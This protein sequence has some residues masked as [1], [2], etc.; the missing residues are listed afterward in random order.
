MGMSSERRRELARVAMKQAAPPRCPF[1]AGNIP[2]GKRGGVCSQGNCRPYTENH[3][4]DRIGEPTG[5]PIIM[6][7]K[8]FEQGGVVHRW[9]ADIVGFR[10]VYVAQEVPFMRSP[11]TSRAAG[12]IDLVPYL[13]SSFTGG[14]AWGWGLSTQ[15]NHP[16]GQLETQ[17]QVVKKQEWSLPLLQFSGVLEICRVLV[18]FVEDYRS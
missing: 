7:P 17:E 10:D 14:L 15:R 9:L 1:Q 3:L 16:R 12:R 18:E 13:G 5:P 8:R 11:E 4:T 2:C 6:C